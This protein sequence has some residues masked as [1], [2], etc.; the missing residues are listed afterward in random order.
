MNNENA[1]TACRDVLAE[2]E[3]WQLNYSLLHKPVKGCPL[4][5]TCLTKWSK[6]LNTDGAA[7]AKDFSILRKA[8]PQSSSIGLPLGLKQLLLSSQVVLTSMELLKNMAIAGGAS[9]LQSVDLQI[10]LE[11][12]MEMC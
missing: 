4:L 7:A 5:Q 9:S 8:A 6:P 2:T 1:Q 10:S 12:M 11:E 3:L